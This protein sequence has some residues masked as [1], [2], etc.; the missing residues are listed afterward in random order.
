M[1]R[2]NMAAWAAAVVLLAVLM[3]IVLRPQSQ[4]IFYR[5]SGGR[6]SMTI[7][8]SIHVGSREMY[9]FGKNIREALEQAD[10]LVFECDTQSEEAMRLTAEMMTLPQ[11]STLSALLSETCTEKLEHASAKLGY[12]N[13]ALQTFKP[14]AVVSMLSV[15]DTSQDMNAQ[16][17]LGVENVVRKSAQGKP[18]I[19]LETTREQ[20]EML[21]GMSMELQ[22]YLLESACDE[23]LAGTIGETSSW[24]KWWSKG[25]TEAFAQNYRD[26]MHAEADPILAAEYHTVLL[27]QRNRR[28]AERLSQMLESDE[29]HAYFVTIGLM[30]LVLQE[31]SVLTE[32]EKLG[33]TIEQI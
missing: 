9:P 15:A 33:Y 29:P 3:V 5:V 32:L 27:T 16:K 8:G 28:M 21:D 23:V 30:H 1:K 24:P 25:E 31:D 20:L 2:K 14:W 19:W 11:G 10:V 22:S 17:A 26:E 18:E 4:G 13:A 12:D 7:L 6:N